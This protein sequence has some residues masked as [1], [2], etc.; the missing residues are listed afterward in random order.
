MNETTDEGR[1]NQFLEDGQRPL[2]SVIV[3]VYN[4]ARFVD[5]CL[6]SVMAQT[7]PSWELLVVDDASTD[8][9]LAE[10]EKTLSGES[11][12]CVIRRRENSGHPGIVRNQA[13]RRAKGKYVAFL[14]A[15][16]CWKPGKLATQV[17]YME[18][19]P[20]YPFT[21]TVC[22]EIDAD[23][24]ILRVRHG[25]QLPAP[26]DCLPDLFRHCFICT[27]TVMV[28]R[29]FGEQMNW[30]T[31][32]PEYRCGEDYDFFVR[33][34]KNSGIG[35]PEGIWGQY[36]NVEGSISHRDA[37][38]KNTPADYMRS[39]YFLRK[40]NLWKGRIPATDMRRLAWQAAQENCQYWRARA[41]WVRARWFVV[42][43]LKLRPMAVDTWRQLGGVALR[44]R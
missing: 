5:D 42:E 21:H 10:V 13:L 38:W 40:Q 6:R 12:A 33:C 2:V 30:F 28:R 16:D 9:S 24:N 18:T 29:D 17:S 43:M 35:I 23:G 41:R 20:E 11:R 7:Y 36:R 14:D 3:G 1:Q 22:E 39:L 34:A 26:G 27:S 32:S 4:K 31:E 37:N 15:D 8:G 25:G 19:H 44:R